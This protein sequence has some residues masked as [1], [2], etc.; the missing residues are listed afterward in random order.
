MESEIPFV[1]MIGAPRSGTTWLQAM[2][3]AHPE[4]GTSHELKLFDLFTEP[5]ARSWQK[6]IDIQRSEGGGRRGLRIVWSDEEFRAF[7]GDFVRNIHSRVLATKPGATIVLDKSP[8]Y[9]RHV[10]HIDRLMPRTKFLHVIRDGRDVAASLRAASAGWAR[11]WA[12]GSIASAAS[13]WRST[14][15][16]A[17]DGRSLGPSRYL[18]IRF[19]DVLADGP[20]SLMGLFAFIGVPTT[21]QRCVDICDAHTLTAMRDSRAFE[22]PAEF[23]RSGRAGTWRTELR[24]IDRYLFDE[25][26]GDLLCELGYASPDWWIERR[27]ERWMVP[28]FAMAPARRLARAIARRWSDGD[29][30][31]DRG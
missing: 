29:A 22:L 11:T 14:V 12:P 10:A 6:L 25:I 2:L 18:E 15:Q 7:L 28:L 16:G 27:H 3:G 24:A 8:G 4:V 17:R 20:G 1:C 19:E 9:S 5:W 23:F 13:L 21:H 31:V 30:R 26:A